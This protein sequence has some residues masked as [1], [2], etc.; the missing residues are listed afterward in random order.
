MDFFPY[1]KDKPFVFSFTADDTLGTNETVIFLPK[2][3]YP[4]GVR[5]TQTAGK[6]T[7]SIDWRKQTLM[8]RHVRHSGSDDDGREHSLVITKA[9]RGSLLRNSQ[10]TQSS[11]DVFEENL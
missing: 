10:T 5:V 11:E 8:Y 1:K 4:Y 3:Q 7:W 9:P 6:G 2:Y